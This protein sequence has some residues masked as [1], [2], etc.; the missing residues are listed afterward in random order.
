MKISMGSKTPDKRTCVVCGKIF[1]AKGN[2]KT[3][4]HLCSDSPKNL[5]SKKRKKLESVLD[6]IRD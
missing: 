3:C 5:G 6:R 2:Q 1:Y 4:D